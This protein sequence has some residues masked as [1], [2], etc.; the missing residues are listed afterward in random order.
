MEQDFNGCLRLEDLDLDIRGRIIWFP[1]MMVVG[2]WYK[3]DIN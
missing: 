1:V 2:L 3:L